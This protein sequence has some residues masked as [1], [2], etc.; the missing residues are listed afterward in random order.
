[1]SILDAEA[2]SLEIRGRHEEAKKI[3][4][5]LSRASVSPDSQKRVSTL[6]QSPEYNLLDQFQ[7]AQSQRQLES[8]KYVLLGEDLLKKNLLSAAGTMAAAGPGAAVSL[9][10]LNAV[11]MGQNLYRVV[12]DN[13][14]SAQ[15]VIDAGVAYVRSHPNS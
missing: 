14:I 10:F 6:L 2:V 13:P 1:D 3:L 15:P 11:M 12:T 4:G 5:E 8:V 7:G 9:G